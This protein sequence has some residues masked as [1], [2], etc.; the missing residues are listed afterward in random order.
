MER[1][2]DMALMSKTAVSRTIF[3]QIAANSATGI[4]PSSI[5]LILVLNCNIG[6][7]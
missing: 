6:V 3:V 4:L 1:K 2:P 5:S 7:K